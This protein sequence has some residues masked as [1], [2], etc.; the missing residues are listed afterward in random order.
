MG[1]LVAAVIVR[2]GFI[3]ALTYVL[4]W[5]VW[6]VRRLRRKIRNLEAR[7]LVQEMQRRSG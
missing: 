1:W 7:V 5:L 4:G 3:L 6:K 2:V